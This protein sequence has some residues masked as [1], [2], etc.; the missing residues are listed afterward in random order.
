MNALLT[1]SFLALAVAA[2]G[3]FWVSSELD[4]AGPL[5]E[6]RSVVIRRGEG[7]RDIARRLEREGLISS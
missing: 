1:F 3:V 6:A 5:Q 4:K 7:A 2:G